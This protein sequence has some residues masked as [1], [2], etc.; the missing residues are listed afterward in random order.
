MNLEQSIWQFNQALAFYHEGESK[1]AIY[2][3]EKL[4]SE[5][6]LKDVQCEDFYAHIQ[7][8]LIFIYG[9]R[10]DTRNAS[11]IFR[12]FPKGNY[13]KYIFSQWILLV[14]YLNDQ[15][16]LEFFNLIEQFKAE[17]V[18]YLGNV[19]YIFDLY[20]NI[21]NKSNREKLLTLHLGVYKILN[22]IVINQ[23]A[24]NLIAHYTNPT[25]AYLMLDHKAPKPVSK[26]RLNP[27]DFMND[28][29]EGALDLFHKSKNDLPFAAYLYRRILNNHA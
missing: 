20:I 27:I 9:M 17:D 26:F 1:E 5:I 7:L 13:P 18:Q 28:P 29:T 19:Y 10:S 22:L 24:D 23:N 11:V 14:L 4:S 16:N 21:K 12:K 8:V 15:D 25:V 6:D 3:L 2:I